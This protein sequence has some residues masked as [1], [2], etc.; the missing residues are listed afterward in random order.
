MNKNTI[1]RVKIP[2]ALYESIKGKVLNE[3]APMHPSNEPWVVWVQPDGEEKR[4]MRTVP[5]QKVNT[6]I[7]NL[8]S[9]Y[10]GDFIQIGACPESEWETESLSEA[11]KKPSAGLTKKEKSAVV[12]KAKSG[13]DIGKK[14]K[15]F[16]KVAAKA[17]K[18]YGS[19]ERGQKVA[20]AAMWKGQAAKKK[21]K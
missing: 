11:K 20:A 12:K 8:F 16:E 7:T 13:K 21:A 4:K 10:D 14:G 19:K 6:V 15:G 17:A 2:M 1:V 18:E 5:K 9:M 3:E